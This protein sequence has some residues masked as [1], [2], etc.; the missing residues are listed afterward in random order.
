ML[1]AVIIFF[2]LPVSFLVAA[3]RQVMRAR[4]EGAMTNRRWHCS[5]LALALA[6]I[7]VA[8]TLIQ[9]LSW[10]INGGSPHGME[11]GP[12][13]WMWMRHV[14]LWLLVGM[15]AMS[16]FAWGRAKWWLA[17]IGP[18]IMFVAYALYMLQFD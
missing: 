18:A 17:A 12:G 3:F 4:R 7:T 9:E 6:S 10:F 2:L 8:W 14:S 11:A 15:F 5:V 1:I 13:I 16:F